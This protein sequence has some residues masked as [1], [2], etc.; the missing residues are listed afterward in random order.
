MTVFNNRV[1]TA[2]LR[3]RDRKK[4]IPVLLLFLVIIASGFTGDENERALNALLESWQPAQGVCT[5][6]WADAPMYGRGE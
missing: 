2:Y 6:A 4:L 5:V 3:K 1:A